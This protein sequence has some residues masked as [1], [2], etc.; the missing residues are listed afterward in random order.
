MTPPPL[1]P[2]HPTCE[3]FT[4]KMIELGKGEKGDHPFTFTCKNGTVLQL[5]R[6]PDILGGIIW[7]GALVLSEYLQSHE[8]LNGKRVIELGA[9]LGL[10]G[11]VAAECGASEVVNTDVSVAF[12]FPFPRSIF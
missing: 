6:K 3:R 10:C 7:D 5:E 12:P 11:F 8:D 4:Q 1:F 9:G 2:L